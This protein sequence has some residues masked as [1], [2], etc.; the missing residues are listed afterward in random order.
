MSLLSSARCQILGFSATVYC[1]Y[2]SKPKSETPQWTSFLHDFGS[3][4][5]S[6]KSVPQR[7]LTFDRECARCC[8]A[9]GAYGLL[10]GTVHHVAGTA[11]FPSPLTRRAGLVF[12]WVRPSCPD[13]RER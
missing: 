5:S 9:T 1:G 7:A 4:H 3:V 10:G 11:N 2:R 8:R 12:D 6:G 13:C